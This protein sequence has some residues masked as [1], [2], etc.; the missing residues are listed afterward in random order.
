MSNGWNRPSGNA[1]PA[2]KKNPT[3]IRGALAGIAVVILAAIAAFFIFSGKET[4]QDDASKKE[5]GRIKEVTPAAAAKSVE[6]VAKA[7][8]EKKPAKSI[9]PRV[10]NGKVVRPPWPPNPHGVI[11][12]GL[13][14]VKSVE[15]IAFTHY[16]DQQIASLLITE[17]GE[18]LVGDDEERMFKDFDKN[19]LKSLVEPIIVEE[20]DTP[21][22]KDLKKAVR[23]TKIDL[24]ARMDAGEDIKQIMIDSRKELRELGLYRDELNQQLR[25][26]MN[27]NKDMSADDLRD[28]VNAANKML[29]DRGAKK[30]TMPETFIRRAEIRA[31]KMRREAEAKNAGQN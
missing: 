27:E 24:K 12:S 9:D 29:E 28:L 18:G 5:R 15:E 13:H 19:F 26:M 2:P 23:Q 11:T 21:F 6:A 25:T 17:P 20:T 1:K 10:E 14:R 8:A 4:R 31:N 16:S 3:A 30:L 22:V 7:E